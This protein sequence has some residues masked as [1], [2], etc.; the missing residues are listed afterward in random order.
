VPLVLGAG[1]LQEVEPLE[2][3]REF[4]GLGPYSPWAC[5][6]TTPPASPPSRSAVAEPDMRVAAGVFGNVDMGFGV[7]QDVACWATM[8]HDPHSV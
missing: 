1:I 4:V 7:P 5:P 2:V 3:A 6:A 8:P